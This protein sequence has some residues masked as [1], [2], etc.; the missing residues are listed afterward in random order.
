MKHL[1]YA[2]LL[3][4][5]IASAQP[6]DTTFVYLNNGCVDAYPADLATVGDMVGGTLEVIWND[7]TIVSY[8]ADDIACV[9]HKGPKDLPQLTSFK[10]NNKFNDQVY[11]DVE[12]TV[13]DRRIDLQLGCIGR[14]LTP[15]FQLSDEQAAAYIGSELQ[16]SKISRR[17]YDTDVTYTIALPGMQILRRQ[18]TTDSHPPKYAMEPYGR[19]YTLHIDWL[20]DHATNVP[21]VNINIENGQMVSSK[22]YYLN[23]EI[24]IDGAGVF[25]SMG[26]TAVQIKGRGNSSWSSNPW[27]K[28]PYRLK[29]DKKQKPFGLSNAKSWVLLAN[30]QKGSMLSN[31]IGMKAACLAETAA[32]NHMIPVELYINGDYRGSYNFTEK[33][34]FAGNSIDLDDETDAVLIELDT[35]Y[36]ETYKFHSDPYRLPVNIKEPDFSEGETQLTRDD[37]KGDFNHVM[38]QLKEGQEIAELVD[39]EYLARYLLV[40]E[41]IMNFELM[42]PK[43]TYLYKERV[44]GGSKYI[45]G[46]VWDLDWA[47]GYELNYKYCVG[48]EQANYYNR[49]NMEANQ[50][51]HDLR[52]VSP[53]LDRTYYKV[54]TR[55]MR[56]SLDELIDFCADYYAYARSSLEHNYQKWGDGNNYAV[57]ATNAA[58]WLRQRAEYIYSHLTAYEL[59]DEEINGETGIN[60]VL[61]RD[62]RW[63]TGLADVYNLQGICVKRQVPVSELRSTLPPG[64]YLVNGNKFVI[65]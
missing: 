55:F 52:Y 19:D 15:S 6:A 24:S 34:G 45:F 7:N 59:T 33:V 23:A 2:L 22:D 9:T 10:I 58:N 49:V 65:K 1:Y 12:A 21:T 54:W 43:S 61:I 47:Y 30:K 56:N 17:R 29:F 36:D 57:S 28:N 3:W 44:K 53:K 48:E 16:R 27:D 64:L 63:T 46:P 37:I 38:Q 14:W 26:A 11:T 4:A 42:H 41:L 60:D 35:Y 25:P 39:L 13:S 5:T 62:A 8:A 32:A 31:A 51:M 18:Q 40:N 50:F 20:T